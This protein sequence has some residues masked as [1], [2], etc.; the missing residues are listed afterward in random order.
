MSYQHKSINILFF[1]LLFLMSLTLTAQN[2]NNNINQYPIQF[3][4][5]QSAFKISYILKKNALK[6]RWHIEPGYFLYK[7][8]IKIVTNSKPIKINLPKGESYNDPIF[9]KVKIYKD[10]LILNILLSKNEIQ[11]E[12]LDCMIHI[13]RMLYL[14]NELKYST[15]ALNKFRFLKK[16]AGG[17]VAGPAQP[18]T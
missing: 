13:F 12:I 6:I 3:L 16:V 8:K 1:A 14:K 18:K 2:T 10:K 17:N 7:N 15:L 5:K 11:V 9:G 4:D